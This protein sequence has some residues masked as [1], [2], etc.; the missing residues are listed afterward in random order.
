MLELLLPKAVLRVSRAVL[1]V[2]TCGARYNESMKKHPIWLT[3]AVLLVLTFGTIYG[4]VQQ[5]QRTAAND[6]QIQIAQDTAAAINAGKD[7]TMLG[8]DKVDMARSLSP[9]VIVY[10]TNGKVV[11]GSGYLNGL[12]P[13]MPIGVLKA[14]NGQ[15]YHAVTWQPQ[16]DV[17]IA[18]VSVKANNYYVTS[19]RS[20]TEVERNE[21]HT[22]QITG[23]G[24]VASLLVLAVGFILSHAKKHA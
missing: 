17:R 20:L 13:A 11:A 23:F 7:P 19:G 10:D 1:A 22:L 5:A 2:A 6:P 24:L 21:Q 8:P 9:F 3:A 14:S 12:V 15:P 18:S 16:A 4:A